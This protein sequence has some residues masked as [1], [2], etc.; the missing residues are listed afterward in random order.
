MASTAARTTWA[1]VVPRVKPRIVPRAYG[2]HHGAPSP[3]RAGTK[4]TPPESGTDSAMG[5]A[6]D[7]V[8][9]TLMPSRSHCSAAP[10]T[11]IDPS[12]AYVGRSPCPQ[13]IVVMSPEV[14]TGAR[15]P[16]FINTNDPVPYVFFVVPGVKQ[17]W[18][19]SAA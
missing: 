9:R 2:S 19:K 4:Y 16:V 11:K 15:S 8:R 10:V 18:P 7:D 6:S 1:R 14:E 12:S 5:P 3:V 17:A 13:A